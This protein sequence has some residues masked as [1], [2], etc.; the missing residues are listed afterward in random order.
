VF[1]S[2]RKIKQRWLKLTQSVIFCSILSVAILAFVLIEK[3]KLALLGAI[4]E[5]IINIYYY[6]IDFFENGIRHNEKHRRRKAIL[7]FWRKNWIAIFFGI[8]LPLLIYVFAEQMI[9][10]KI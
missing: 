6:A 1:D 5:I 4:V 3:P 8:L 7:T 2:F 10:L 9:L